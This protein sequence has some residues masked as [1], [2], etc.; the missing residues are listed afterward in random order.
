VATAQS[1]LWEIEALQASDLA[2]L[3]LYSSQ[4]VEAYRSD[5]LAFGSLPGLGGVQ[6]SLGAFHLISPAR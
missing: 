6:G 3:P 4:I 5:V 2:Y 1:L